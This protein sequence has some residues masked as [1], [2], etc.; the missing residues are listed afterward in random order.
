MP[1]RA[2]TAMGKRPRRALRWCQRQAQ[3]VCVEEDPVTPGHFQATVAHVTQQGVAVLAEV[4]TDLVVSPSVQFHFRQAQEPSTQKQVAHSVHLRVR[5]VALGGGHAEAADSTQRCLQPALS[6]L[7]QAVAQ[8]DVALADAPDGELQLGRVVARVGFGAQNGTGGAPIQPVQQAMRQACVEANW[9]DGREVLHHPL[10][11]WPCALALLQPHCLNLILAL[12]HGNRPARRLPDRSHTTLLAKDA[13]LVWP[14]A[15]W[16]QRTNLHV[17]LCCGRCA[18]QTCSHSLQHLRT[19]GQQPL[20]QAPKGCK[21]L[22]QSK[23][24]LADL[25]A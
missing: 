25:H 16:Q 14:S 1:T 4:R 20:W 22:Q 2:H 5:A 6:S 18:I 8:A 9:A 17:G 23:G 21:G 24:V 19:Q 7:H 13:W 10:L 12:A 3:E 15:L 11:Q